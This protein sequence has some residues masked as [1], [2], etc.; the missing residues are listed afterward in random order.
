MSRNADLWYLGHERTIKKHST[1]LNIPSKRKGITPKAGSAVKN[2]TAAAYKAPE[3]MVKIPKRKNKTSGMTAAKNHVD[4]ISRNGKLELE[5]QD[6]NKHKGKKQIHENVL[7]QWK[8]LGIPQESKYRETLNVV[9]SMPPGTPPEAV[10]D[11]AREFAKETFQNHHYVFVQHTD[12]KHPHVH[13][14][15]TMRDM[16]GERMN[17]RKNDLHAWRVL[18]AEKLRDQGVECAAT[19]RVHRGQWQKG[20]SSEIHHMTKRNAPSYV[21]QE[22]FNDL[23]EAL[24]YRRPPD[25]PALKQQLDSRDFVVEQYKT[26]SQ[27][28]YKEG[29]KTEAKAIKQLAKELSENQPETKAQQAFKEASKQIDRH[30]NERHINH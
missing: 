26:L 23:V 22:Q 30:I 13:I 29:F 19:K 2:L 17:P 3:V 11:A 21:T 4:Y 18:F 5:D 20:V 28:L 6:G 9:L 24:K 1:G 7:N 25:N 10:K 12:E 15:V 16:N 8:K 27:L 14:C